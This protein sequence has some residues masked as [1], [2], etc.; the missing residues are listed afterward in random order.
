MVGSVIS[1][2]TAGVSA[3][4]TDTGVS[5]EFVIPMGATGPKGE[6]GATG[7]TGP[8]GIQGV[9]GPKGETGATGA[10]GPA[11]IQGVTGPKGETGA[12]G[13]TGPV[14]IQ[15]VTGPK[16]ETGATG[17]TGPAGIQGA[18]GPKGETGATGAT[19]PAG[20]QGVTGPKGET[21][22]VPQVEVAE[23]TKTSY[24]VRFKTDAQEIV[25]PNL[26]ANVET[27]NYNLSVLG[28]TVNIPLDNLILTARNTSTTSMRL[29]IKPKNTGTSVLTDIR[30][31]TIYDSVIE[32]Q[33]NNN[34]TISAEFTLDDLVYT[35]SQETHWMRI[36]Q[37]DPATK[38]WSLCEV[39]TFA[40]Q[41]GSRTSF[42]VNWIYTGSTF[43]TP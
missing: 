13:A 14:G 3:I 29:T 22:A 30:R 42:W 19:G 34:T 11:G 38:L 35:M 2:E 20:I 33:T 18:T 10:T 39:Y 7:A 24:K 26:K 4:P 12:T 43:A 16:G 40:S 21:G 8:A 5:L 28:S 9:T 25:S 17:A 41:N 27:Y 1:G 15:G 31:T 6:T 32:T 23:D 37:Q 36:R